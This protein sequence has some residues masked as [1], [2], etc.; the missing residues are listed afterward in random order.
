MTDSVRVIWEYLTTTGTTL[1]ALVSTRV[2]AP[3]SPTNWKNEIP[4]LVFELLDEERTAEP[5]TSAQVS[6]RCYG[7][8]TQDGKDYSHDDARSVY[9]L[10]ADCLNAADGARTS[11]GTI[12]M[13]VQTGGTQSYGEDG[14]DWPVVECQYRF[15][16]E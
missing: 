7:G 4:C 13:C 12:L 5:R 2:W 1:N 11:S 10:L 3:E 14:T 6:F 16:I 15:E 8:K 9:R